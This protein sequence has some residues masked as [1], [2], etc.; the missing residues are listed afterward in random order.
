MKILR[1]IFTVISFSLLTSCLKEDKFV[2][3]DNINEINSIVSTIIK[4]D[5]LNLNKGNQNKTVLIENFE[6]KEIIDES[7]IIKDSLIQIHILEPNQISLNSLYHLWEKENKILGFSKQDSLYLLSQ[8]LNPDS[9]KIPNQILS[10]SE[11]L[12]M[13]QIKENDFNRWY[14][15]YIPLISKDK[16]SAYVELDYVCGGLC[17]NGRAYFLQKINGKWII[18]DKWGTWIS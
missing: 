1:I 10:K 18:I 5:S 17:G 4:D 7:K 14:R 12:T 13:K 11:H 2:I 6:K 16:T 9:L 3:E 15:F 8:N